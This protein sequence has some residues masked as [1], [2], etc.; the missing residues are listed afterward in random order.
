[1]VRF[2]LNRENYAKRYVLGRNGVDEAMIIDADQNRTRCR[3]T[4]RE[5]ILCCGSSSGSCSSSVVVV[6]CTRV[7]TLCVGMSGGVYRLPSSA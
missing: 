1:M 5:L 2:M 7:A 3:C 4:K 6:V